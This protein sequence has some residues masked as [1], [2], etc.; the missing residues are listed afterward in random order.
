MD[1]CFWYNV[2]WRNDRSDGAWGD[3][4]LVSLVVVSCFLTYIRICADIRRLHDLGVS[5]YMYWAVVLLF[6]AS[7]ML[8]MTL[9]WITVPM[10]LI[11]F[12]VMSGIVFLIFAF[13]R[14]TQGPNKYG[15]DPTGPISS[16]SG[17]LAGLAQKTKRLKELGVMKSSGR[18]TESEY[19]IRR[20]Q[21]LNGD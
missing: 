1:S 10:S 19:A 13:M 4:L 9:S 12:A 14:G 17:D 18:I 20:A 21:I 2:D 15:P 11:L 7:A 8:A 5:G 3:L 6:S 16:K